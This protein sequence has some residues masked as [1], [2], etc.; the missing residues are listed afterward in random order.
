MKYKK[1]ELFFVW[2]LR[3]L[4]NYMEIYSIICYNQNTDKIILE[5]F[6]EFFGNVYYVFF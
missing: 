3:F 5:G 1:A 4:S 2:R 6:F